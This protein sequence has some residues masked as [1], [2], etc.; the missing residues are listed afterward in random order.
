[1]SRLSQVDNVAA[2]V[3]KAEQDYINGNTTISKHV[4]FN[5]FELNNRI[6]AYL[7]SKFT[8]GDSE[9]PFFNIVTAARNIWYRATDIDRK[10]VRIKAGKMK[11]KVASFVATMHLQEWMRRTG[12]G[13]FLNDWGRNL[14]SYGS[15]VLKFVEK[16]GD[17]IPAVIPWN[18]LITDSVDFENNP[19]VEVLWMTPAQLLKNKSYDQKMVERLLDTRESRETL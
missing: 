19:K 1:M 10:H 5:Q 16:N 6:D 17:L 3:R 15:T 11:Q 7:N 13:A 14:A 18:R 2:L 4:D 8:E 12:F 9:R